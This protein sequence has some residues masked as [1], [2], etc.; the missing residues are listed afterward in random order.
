MMISDQGS[1]LIDKFLK[2]ITTKVD[3]RKFRWEFLK[4]FNT[5][6]KSLFSSLAEDDFPE[7]DLFRPLKM[8]P[9][10]IPIPIPIPIPPYVDYSEKKYCL[11]FKEGV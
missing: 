5:N 10:P 9:T 3:E 1:E 8:P 4:G 7:V 2:V 11:P 6:C